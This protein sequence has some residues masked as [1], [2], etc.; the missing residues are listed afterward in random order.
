MTTKWDRPPL[1]HVIAQ[2][3]F[4]SIEAMEKYAPE[5]QDVLRKKFPLS[6]KTALQHISVIQDQITQQQKSE[7]QNIPLWIYSDPQKGSG[8][9]LAQSALSF[10]A[11]IYEGHEW[12]FDNLFDGMEVVNRIVDPRI[13]TRIGL[14]YVNVLLPEE[15]ETLSSY[16]AE[17]LRG[18]N[19]GFAV[20]QAVTEHIFDYNSGSPYF[21]IKTM[22]AKTS[23]VTGAISFPADI[24]PWGLD[25]NPAY[26]GTTL[27][28]Y[29][30]L[31]IDHFSFGA[32]PLDLPE[33]RR[34]MEAMHAQT[35]T[36]LLDM[37]SEKTHQLWGVK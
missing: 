27:P 32:S 18:I 13:I 15:G 12:L 17:G 8:Y 33:I 3:Q 20:R 11:S 19:S 23:K 34:Q 30:L 16:L 4:G 14:R 2:V 1:L 5:I 25:I 24:S 21:A 26:S 37:V 31:D 35:K 9:V 29:M 7:I 10:H 28:E 22:R 6:E 36:M